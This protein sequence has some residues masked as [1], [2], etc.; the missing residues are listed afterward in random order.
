MARPI[1]QTDASLPLE[2]GTRVA[3]IAS[4]YH[5]ELVEAMVASAKLVLRE[6][7]LE[8]QNLIQIKA[9]GAFE[10][11][12]I[13]QSLLDGSALDAVLCFG[14]VLK[15]ETD[16]DR[17]ISTSVS[18]ALMRIGLEQGIPVMFGLLTC[19]TLE[20]AQ[21]RADPAGLDKGGEVA[22]AAVH[23]LNLLGEL[24]Q[25]QAEDLDFE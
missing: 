23:M 9:P 6:A 14:L 3:I 15:G 10:L 22:R 17:Y 5:G 1:S 24:L 11:P 16:H 25:S 4:T 2:A 7:G 13:A 19:N 21:R 20:Q 18:D 8:D 12:L